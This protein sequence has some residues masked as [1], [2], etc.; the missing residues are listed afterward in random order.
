MKRYRIVFLMAA[1]CGVAMA[2]PAAAQ[3]YPSKPVRLIVPQ[4]AGGGTDT[5]AR[6]LA[7]QVQEQWGQPFVVENRPGANGIIG[8]DY[9]AKSAPDGYTIEM[10]GIGPH[11]INPALFPNLSY[12]AV[13]DF[14]PII[15]TTSA[16]NVLV[17]R[18][19]LPV[20]NVRELVALLKERHDR[21]LSYGSN[22]NGTSVHLAAAMFGLI[23]G[24]EML[25]VP[26]KGSAPVVAAILGGE[27][28]FAYVSILDIMPH[29]RPGGVRAL[30][31][32][33]AR[34]SP[35]MPDVPTIA[36]AGYPGAES[37][38]WFGLVAPAHTPPE[39]VTR[40]NVEFNKA[41]VTPAV[42]K[43]LS[44]NGDTELIGGSPEE[45]AA[46]IKTEIAKWTKVIKDGHIKPD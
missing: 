34:R 36:E 8:T 9:V 4:P 35:A 38:A 32:G 22:G 27:V 5:V 20:K 42:R 1:L 45:F 21:P 16:P 18:G 19:D 12:D 7:A 11:G 3:S 39:I 17:T 30:A 14:A 25:H 10:G 43:R 28:D 24:T 40:L 33:G 26:Y 29:I 13:K 41:L 23:S 15:L 6:V 46:F 2:T 37:S 31:T 44:P